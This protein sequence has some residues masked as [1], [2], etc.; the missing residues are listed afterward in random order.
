MTT[1]IADYFNT[2]SFKEFSD[3]DHGLEWCEEKILQDA[4]FQEQNNFEF[5]S[6]EEQQ[7][8]LSYFSLE[9]FKAGDIVLKQNTPS[10][11]LYWLAEGTLEVWLNDEASYKTRLATIKKGNIIGE[12]G[13]FNKALRTASVIAFD[14]CILYSITEKDLNRLYLE[15][16][17]LWLKFNQYIITTM[18]HRLSNTHHFIQ[19]LKS[20]LIEPQ[21]KTQD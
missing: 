19:Y 5:F 6:A 1:F 11:A 7:Q 16:T 2:F 4:G 8:L 13:F 18:G 9:H 21:N 20:E 17:A 12:M 3:L 10:H 14:N 15:R